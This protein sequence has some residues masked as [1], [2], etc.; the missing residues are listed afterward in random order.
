MKKIILQQDPIDVSAL[1]KTAGTPED[2]AILSF[3]GTPRRFSMDKEV[4]YLHYEAYE[5]MAQKELQ[6]IA[7]T[8]MD[9]WPITNCIIVHRYGKVELG[10]ASIVIAVSS[11]HRDEGFQSLRFIIDTIKKTVPIWKKEVYRDGS[12]WISDRV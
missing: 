10:E 3:I 5:S 4:E 1:L 9:K 8:A 2:G 6:K 11:G 12:V 7:D